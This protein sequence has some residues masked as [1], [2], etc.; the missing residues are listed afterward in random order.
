MSLARGHS[1]PRFWRQCVRISFAPLLLAACSVT[2]RAQVSFEV[3]RITHSEPVAR[4]P[5]VIRAELNDPG[6]YNQIYFRYRAFGAGEYATLEMDLV[7][8]TATVQ[9][10][11]QDVL[12]PFLE[13]YLI[14]MKTD[15]SVETN[16]PG[17]AAAPFESPPGSPLQIQIRG[18]SESS[19]VVLLSPEPAFRPSSDEVIVAF[20]LQRVD[21]TIAKSSTQL[22]LDG[23]D[24]TDHVV[25]SGDLFVFVPGNV[26][27][28]LSGGTHRLTIRLFDQ[29]GFLVDRVHFDFAVSGQG[30]AGAP[31]PPGPSVT[32]SAMAESRHENIATTG[33]WYNR[34]DVRLRGRLDDWS[35]IA[36][37]FVTSDEEPDRQPQNRFFGG[38]ESSWLQLG[39]GDSYP[40]FPSLVMS[41]MR[42]RGF[43]GRLLAG[44]QVFM[45]A[46][47]EVNRPIDGALLA[48]IPVDSLGVEQQRDPTAAYGPL[49]GSTDWGKFSYGTYQRDLLVLRT[50]TLLGRSGGIGLTVLK[51][52]DDVGSIT[53][54]SRPQE[55]AVVALDFRGGFDSRRVEFSGQAAFS[56]YNFDISSGTFSDEYIDTTF[57]DRASD[58]KT[59]KDIL[60]SFITVNDN[61]RPLSFNELATLA[62]EFGVRLNYFNNNFSAQYVFRGSDY[63][64]FGQAYIR[65]DIQGITLSDRIALSSNQIL[66][67]L[68]FELLQDNT[69]NFKVATT[70]F[71]NITAALSYYP[72]NDGPTI[73]VGLGRYSSDNGLSTTGA[74]SPQSIDDV[75]NR[76]Y[77]QSSYGF[78]F[79]ARHIASFNLSTSSRT[80]N[81]PRRLDVNSTTSSLQLR[82][83][84]TVPLETKFDVAFSFNSLPSGV[85]GVQQQSDYTTLSL[86]GLYRVFQERLSLEARISPTLGDVRRTIYEGAIGYAIQRNLTIQMRFTY[87]ANQMV[88][89][90]SIWR[91]TLRYDF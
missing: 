57:G 61:L 87:L 36:N 52:K 82:S 34:A 3:A 58:I 48:Q 64:S 16:P 59:V 86:S 45:A 53:Y 56:A 21:S 60:G 46:S 27:I 49:P 6:Q 65:T 79:G 81:S 62:Y 44:P 7:G 11:A 17:E 9:V 18:E 76:V 63:R 70:K 12:P 33:T 88:A 2:V 32:G 66:L 55:N 85:A 28:A 43:S 91:T 38:V 37:A 50:E 24:V 73:T 83:R 29:A 72:R 84:F 8:N 10:A 23:T 78:D 1:L 67:S 13:Y 25:A 47:G 4:T 5:L 30:L 75:D 68:G 31:L 22:W 41:G 69:S 42:I 90:D 35:V 15:G 71:Q 20:S 19:D 51:G 14:F 40:V 74:D 89:D 80:D 54:G 39:Y 26:G 77:L